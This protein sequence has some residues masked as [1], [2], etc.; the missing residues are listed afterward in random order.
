MIDRTSSPCVMPNVQR[1]GCHTRLRRHQRISP[2]RPMSRAGAARKQPCRLLLRRR[3]TPASPDRFLTLVTE[4]SDALGSSAG[5]KGLREAHGE[6]A[7][8]VCDVI[9]LRNR[10][11]LRRCGRGSGGRGISPPCRGR[12]PHTLAGRLPDA[13]RASILAGC[14]GHQR[15]QCL[16]GREPEVRPVCRS[17]EWSALASL[18]HTSSGRFRRAVDSGPPGWGSLG[19]RIRVEH[20]SVGRH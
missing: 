10:H 19:P 13:F 11:C 20:S 12:G 17:L 7:Y 18:G 5:G 6:I 4:L 2:S 16:G 1:L 14:G 9:R 15:D 3:R 8:Q